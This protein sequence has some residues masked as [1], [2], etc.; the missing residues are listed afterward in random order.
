M[1]INTEFPVSLTHF[2]ERLA[3]VSQLCED[4]RLGL[5]TGGGRVNRSCAIERIDDH[6]QINPD[7]N[8]FRQTPGRC[9]DA[10]AW[11]NSVVAVF[12]GERRRF[13]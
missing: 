12:A 10:A 3:P 4:G 13:R 7:W 6:R 5:L 1:I 8:K 2:A 9:V 11:D